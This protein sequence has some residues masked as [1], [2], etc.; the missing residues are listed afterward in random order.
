[1]NSRFL[2]R[3]LSVVAALMLAF[4]IALP[5][6]AVDGE[7]QARRLP[8]FHDFSSAQLD[9]LRTISESHGINGLIG[10]NGDYALKDGDTPTK[11]I[12]L[13]GNDPAATQVL[14]AKLSGKSLSLSKAIQNVKADH[15]NFKKELKSVAASA[16]LKFEYSDAINGAA[17]TLPANQ[18][19][20]LAALPTVRAV[21]PDRLV[22]IDAPSAPYT[23]RDPEG[24]QTGRAH[25]GANDLHA[26]G[27]T[28]KGVT[29]AILDTG[30]DYNHPAFAGAFLTESPTKDPA[31]LIDG[32]FYGRNYVNE[33]EYGYPLYNDGT[34]AAKNDPMETT[35]YG[36]EGTDYPEEIPGLG[37]FYTSHGTHVAGT[38]AGR[39]VAAD[40]ADGT[41][42]VLGMAPEANIYSYRVL[43]P[44]G[45]G[46][47]SG[48]IAAINQVATDKPDVVNMSLGSSVNDPFDLQAIAVNN[49]T[50]DPANNN[51]LFAISASNSGEY[52]LYS[53]GTPGVASLAITVGAASEPNNQAGIIG[54]GVQFGFTATKAGSLVTDKAYGVVYMPQLTVLES[55]VAVPGIGSGSSEEWAKLLGFVTPEV[56]QLADWLEIISVESARDLV[57]FIYYSNNTAD[58][59]GFFGEIGTDIDFEDALDIIAYYLFDIDFEAAFPDS[60]DYYDDLAVILDGTLE[61]L[62]GILGIETTA[63]LFDVASQGWDDYVQA[64]NDA[65]ADDSPIAGKFVVLGRGQNFQSNHDWAKKYGAAGVILVDRVT[66]ALSADSVGVKGD[67]PFLY[68]DNAQGLKFTKT[69]PDTLTFSKFVK[70]NT[71][72]ADLSSRGPVNGSYEIK[73]DVLAQGIDV[74]SSVPK[75]ITGNHKATDYADAYEGGWNGTSMS[76]PHVA[77][78]I[79]LL[80][81][82]T[83]GLSSGELKAL[84]MNNAEILDGNYSVYETGAG[85]IQV[86]KAYE[87]SKLG[88]V[89]VAYDDANISVVEEI[90]GGDGA[91]QTSLK[92][93]ISDTGSFSFGGVDVFSKDG[94]G[95]SESIYTKTLT[96]TIHNTSGTDKTYSLS[97]EKNAA[98]NGAATKW[99]TGASLVL[100]QSSVP[101]SAGATADFTATLTLPAGLTLDNVGSYE[102]LITVTSG[103]ESYSLPFAARVSEDRP[104]I[105]NVEL[106]RNL[107]ST[108]PNSLDWSGAFIDVTYNSWRES[109]QEYFLFD[110][111]TFDPTNWDNGALAGELFL[112][113]SYSDVNDGSSVSATLPLGA[114]LTPDE[115]LIPIPQ[116]EYILAWNSFD[117]N[118][119]YLGD[120]YAKNAH[121]I[122]D[123]TPA[124]LALSGLENGVVATGST[125]TGTVTKA[126]SD[127]ALFASVNGADAEPVALLGG[128]AFNYKVPADAKTVTFYAV[129]NYQQHLDTF[130]YFGSPLK[131]SD[132]WE[133]K[134]PI[135]PNTA[136]GK[137]WIGGNV[138]ETTLLVADA[139]PDSITIKG[140]EG[141]YLSSTLLDTLLDGEIQLIVDLDQSSL[142]PDQDA[143][144]AVADWIDELGGSA[145]FYLYAEENTKVTGLDFDPQAVVYNLGIV[146][147]GTEVDDLNGGTVH[148][149]AAYTLPEKASVKTLTISPIKAEDVDTLAQKEP[150]LADGTYN[151]D[152]SVEFTALHFSWYVVEVDLLG[153]SYD[154][155]HWYD[156]YI[157]DLDP[158]GTGIWKDY[159][160]ADGYLD[161]NAEIT[162]IQFVVSLL[163]SLEIEPV[164]Y[165]ATETSLA[166]A[167]SV[168]SS[169]SISSPT[170]LVPFLDADQLTDEQQGY[171]YA[172]QSIGI[173]NG[174]GDDLFDPYGDAERVHQ[175]QI[176]WKLLKYQEADLT[177]I[178]ELTVADFADPE[179]I[180]DWALQATSALIA[181]GE[182]TGDR[183]LTLARSAASNLKGGR[184]LL[185]SDL[186]ALLYRH[187]L[188]AE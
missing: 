178:N 49:V 110:A 94:F 117:V 105:T 156:D 144:Q 47:G 64:A 12:V 130:T 56:P 169:T 60:A 135:A 184:T 88:Y 91:T 69:L 53:L 128:G 66:G 177:A 152:G 30:I 138:T 158:A 142:Y 73:P 50:L 136:D 129:D 3:S 72:L 4:S 113:M 26:L 170:T 186:A 6:F 182:V 7:A 161:A 174:V 29:V 33:A 137:S 185:L 59:A 40:A 155:G 119:R 9:A 172:A 114:L 181:I 27:Y 100:G 115:E 22:T 171:L 70:A 23:G 35:Y 17:L 81:Q 118:N 34:V 150:P 14:S 44:Y 167:T 83:D 173:V 176:I 39:D 95:A 146:V 131:I 77:G 139:V 168:A 15:A 5:S 96:A 163:K 122:V 76:S 89:T 107:I 92:K 159:L 99:P 127:N 62:L 74:Y 103:A 2:K 78:A 120:G 28:G 10:F 61:N 46:Y 97:Y 145:Y 57:Q 82:A 13:F 31:D 37:E 54:G 124:A 175:F 121:V 25:T 84:L 116:G 98:G 109:I 32:V 63:D 80:K 102:G 133:W 151:E 126:G 134:Y 165:V 183:D 160:D 16:A 18:V 106:T 68:L 140:D 86:A 149:R 58:F 187:R 21:Y 180:P 157:E 67:L 87:A 85:Y 24:M 104:I 55:Q 42:G 101:V 79:A 8:N 148:V 141:S 154:R 112:G 45:S 11:V 38:I 125:I 71:K 123:N 179:T 41:P 19:A 90:D 43:G 111:A 166:T 143:L 20:A 162:R 147:N 164:E 1:M 93:A 48:I 108:N 65:I 51:V 153:F 36:W 188:I 75:Y 132:L 52:G